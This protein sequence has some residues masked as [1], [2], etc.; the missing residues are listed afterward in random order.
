[1]LESFPNSVLIL[2]KQSN[3]SSDFSTCRAR[4]DEQ[5][6]PTAS[7]F[8]CMMK[9]WSLNSV[10]TQIIPRRPL[11]RRVIILHSS[12]LIHINHGTTCQITFLHPLP[13]PPYHEIG[14]NI[15]IIFARLASNPYQSEI[16][17]LLLN[18]FELTTNGGRHVIAQVSIP[19]PISSH[20]LHL[21]IIS[22]HL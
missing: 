6:I 16:A 9:V 8:G 12:H 21:Y 3:R 14:K 19:S 22:R 4:S 7:Q 13:F 5:T 11:K 18:I 2:L 15:D 1:M 10:P 20:G 17:R